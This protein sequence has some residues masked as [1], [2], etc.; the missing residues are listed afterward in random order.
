MTIETII[1]RESKA[2]KSTSFNFDQVLI[3]LGGGI[4]AITGQSKSE[5]GD[6]FDLYQAQ[7][8]KAKLF[9]WFCLRSSFVRKMRLI[10]NFKGHLLEDIYSEIL[11]VLGW[12]QI[13]SIGGLIGNGKG[14]DRKYIFYV[15][16]AEEKV[17][18]KLGLTRATQ[19]SIEHEYDTVSNISK[20]SKSTF[21][22]M[23]GLIKTE[24]YSF[25]LSEYLP[26]KGVDF[27][28]VPIYEILEKLVIDEKVKLSK[29]LEEQV[30]IGSLSDSNE[31]LVNRVIEHGDLAPWNMRFTAA[32]G[33]KLI[34]L[35]S[36]K[37][38]GLPLAD[39]VHWY[40]QY[41]KLVENYGPQ[42]IIQEL[43]DEQKTLQYSHYLEVLGINPNISNQLIKLIIGHREQENID[44]KDF[45]SK[46]KFLLD[47]NEEV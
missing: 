29:I 21:P 27:N 37:S 36:S 14:D 1:K 12:T 23:L 44:P 46:H 41:Y 43:N 34:D 47:S 30:T 3:K 45:L 4:V 39:W 19:L 20:Y 22:I 40:V 32:N 25:Y 31:V 10:K 28:K 33:Y 26:S 42:K 24:A 18:L 5:L 6:T 16:N 2:K 11:R 9:K 7:T 17:I 15:R 35:E 8:T 13:T 38:S